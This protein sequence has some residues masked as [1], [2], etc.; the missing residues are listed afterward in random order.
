MC[1]CRA[2]PLGEE[3][4]AAWDGSRPL[5][6]AK[7]RQPAVKQ[8]RAF[9]WPLSS[10]L[11]TFSSSSPGLQVGER[12]LKTMTSQDLQGE[13][14]RRPAAPAESTCQREAE[15]H[16]VGERL[17]CVHSGKAEMNLSEARKIARGTWKM[18]K[19]LF[20]NRK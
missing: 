9:H 3:R 20:E 11:Q 14:G 6:G 19:F 5:A 2:S 15:T 4:F 10:Q 17:L 7:L 1:T 16:G 12:Q 8:P 18:R 13:E